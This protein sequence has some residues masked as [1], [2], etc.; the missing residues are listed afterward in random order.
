MREFLDELKESDPD[1]F[2][3]VDAGYINRGTPN[4]LNFPHQPYRNGDIDLNGR[5]DADDYFDIDKG[6][7][8]Q[9]GRPAAGDGED[10]ERCHL[11]ATQHAD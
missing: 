6:S 10:R 5:V 3:A 11:A 2:A 1:D 7:G 8:G 4:Y 9:S